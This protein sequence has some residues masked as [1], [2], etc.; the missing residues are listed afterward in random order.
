MKFWLIIFII[1]LAVKVYET[2]QKDKQNVKQ[3]KTKSQTQPNFVFNAKRLRFNWP[4][5]TTMMIMMSPIR[6]VVEF[7][8]IFVSETVYRLTTDCPT[9]WLDWTDSNWESLESNEYFAGLSFSFWFWATRNNFQVYCLLL[10]DPGFYRVCFVAWPRIQF[11]LF[12]VVF[13]L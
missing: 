2:Q 13:F 6:V 7:E 1:F 10:Q 4:P 3:N 5:T 9:D 12:F 8:L 11:F